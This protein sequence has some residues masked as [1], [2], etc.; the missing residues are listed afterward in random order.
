MRVPW[1]STLSAAGAAWTQRVRAGALVGGGGGNSRDVCC[2]C[3]PL[4]GPEREPGSGPT[5]TLPS[6]LLPLLQVTCSACCTASPSS[7]TVHL[8]TWAVAER[9][10]S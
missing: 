2:D 1:G 5:L 3:C 4:S 6:L 8:T 7:T 10:P 9:K